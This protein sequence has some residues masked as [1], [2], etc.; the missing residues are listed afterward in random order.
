MLFLFDRKVFDYQLKLRLF[1]VQ[2]ISFPLE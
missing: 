2:K 1:L